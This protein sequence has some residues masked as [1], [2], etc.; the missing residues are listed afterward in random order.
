MPNDNNVIGNGTPALL[1]GVPATAAASGV[2]T[3]LV[4]NGDA[5]AAKL[6]EHANV[7]KSAA[8]K[9]LAALETAGVAVRQPGGRDGGRS[10]PDRWRAA[11]DQAVV[12]AEPSAAAQAAEMPDSDA[13]QAEPPLL[14]AAA[15]GRL[16]RGQLREMVV[17]HLRQHP[18]QEFSTTALG[19]AL[20]HSAG[21]IANAC[22]RLVAIGT[23]TRTSAKPRRYR[24]TRRSKR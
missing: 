12:D 5:T 17:N 24:I 3:A 18:G 1:A 9:V 22:E 6:A 7:S 21:A 20:G 13:D 19:R 11:S 14:P 8:N 4:A 10:L 15:D 2:W 16:A 23:V